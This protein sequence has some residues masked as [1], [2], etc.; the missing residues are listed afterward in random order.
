MRVGKAHA[1]RGTR[2]Q[3]AGEADFP[4]EALGQA[5]HDIEPDAM[6]RAAHGKTASSA[7]FMCLLREGVV[8]FTDVMIAPA[9]E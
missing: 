7:V 9:Q 2:I 3:L 5:P 4:A 1:N 6:A 8:I